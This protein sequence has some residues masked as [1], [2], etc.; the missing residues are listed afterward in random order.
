MTEGERGQ[1][2]SEA[3]NVTS[4]TDGL[5][6]QVVPGLSGSHPFVHYMFFAWVL[7]FQVLGSFFD[8]LPWL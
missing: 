1:E 2:I 3:C 5:L 8:G 4:F 7:G 6:R